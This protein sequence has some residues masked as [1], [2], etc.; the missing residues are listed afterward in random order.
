MSS[1]VPLNPMQYSAL[2]EGGDPE[3]LLNE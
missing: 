2:P 3:A 1:G